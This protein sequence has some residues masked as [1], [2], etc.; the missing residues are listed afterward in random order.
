MAEYENQWGPY[1]EH[2]I[3]KDRDPVLDDPIIYGVNVKH[4]ILRTGESIS[5]GMPAS[6]RM[7][8]G[9]VESPVLGMGRFCASTGY[10]GRPTC[11][12]MTA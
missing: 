4:F 9:T 7:I 1:K 8:W 10:T 12:P 2:S 3:E 5:I 11:L 6:S